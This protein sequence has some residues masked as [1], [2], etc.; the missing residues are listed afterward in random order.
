MSAPEYGTRKY[1]LFCVK[2]R[3]DDMMSEATE[4]PLDFL[5]PLTAEEE[6]ENEQKRIAELASFLVRAAGAK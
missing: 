1:W 2:V 3:L 5:R 4:A 6:E